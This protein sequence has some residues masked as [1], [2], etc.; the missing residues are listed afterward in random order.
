H[1]M[2][3]YVKATGRNGDPL[4]RQ[5][6]ANLATEI[7]SARLLALRGAWMLENG[8]VP[9]YEAAMLKLLVTET[10]QRLVNTMMQIC[11]PYG[12]IR[13]GAKWSQLDGKFERIYRD[14]LENL[15]TRGTSE[16]MRNVVAQRGLGLPR[17]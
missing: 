2:I 8:R 4:V 3:A 15:I 10:E 17:R 5:K 12:Q 14:S 7:A 1:E 11:G 16:I 9:N 13:K 6:L